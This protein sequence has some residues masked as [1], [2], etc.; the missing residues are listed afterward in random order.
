MSKI[1]YL[2]ARAFDGAAVRQHDE[3]IIQ[4]AIA[5]ALVSDDILCEQC[6]VKLGDSVDAAF[7]TALSPL[8]ILLGLARDRGDYGLLP[9]SKTPC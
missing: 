5:G 6:G 2:C 1:C 7:A 4:N 8:T 3:H 9:V